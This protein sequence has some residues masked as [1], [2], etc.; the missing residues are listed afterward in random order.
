MCRWVFLPMHKRRDCY[1]AFQMILSASHGHLLGSP[2]VSRFL[3]RDVT[4]SR[5]EESCKR[6]FTERSMRLSASAL[7]TRRELLYASALRTRR[8]LMNRNV[9]DCG[10]HHP[11]ANVGC[12]DAAPGTGTVSLSLLLHPMEEGG[13]KLYS[14]M[15]WLRRR[16]SG[17]HPWHVVGDRPNSAAIAPR[18][19]SGG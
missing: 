16:R 1:R 7:R 15:L 3:L 17:P 11:T 18:S 10:R 9:C 19:C 2:L 8:E 4:G 5:I 12:H 14:R 6:R 13:V